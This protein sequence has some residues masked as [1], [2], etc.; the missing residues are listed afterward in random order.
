MIDKCAAGIFFMNVNTNKANSSQLM[1]YNIQS[2]DLGN[3]PCSYYYKKKELQ[4]VRF[5]INIRVKAGVH[6]IFKKHTRATRFI[7]QNTV[8]VWCFVHHLDNA[9]QLYCRLLTAQ[10]KT[11]VQYN[12]EK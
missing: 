6:S 1:N 12:K 8:H 10:F 7:V 9:K 5:V 4:V 11:T 2:H 3:L